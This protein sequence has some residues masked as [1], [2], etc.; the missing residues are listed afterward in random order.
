[1]KIT[2]DSDFKICDN[3]LTKSGQ[4]IQQT[5]REKLL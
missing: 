4:T 2:L 3:G 5:K 1:M